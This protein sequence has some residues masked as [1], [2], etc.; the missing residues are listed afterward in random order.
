MWIKTFNKYKLLIS[1]GSDYHGPITKPHISL[2]TGE[3]NNLNINQTIN[4]TII[5]NVDTKSPVLSFIII[6][7]K[8]ATKILNIN[9]ILLFLISSI[10]RVSLLPR[11]PG[12]VL[13]QRMRW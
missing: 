2:G 11:H 4:G 3:N 8:I 1:G 13:R 6:A 7:V 12:F 5:I 9:P 10:I